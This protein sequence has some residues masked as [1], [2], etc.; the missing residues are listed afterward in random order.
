[1]CQIAL[2]VILSPPRLAQVTYAS[3]DDTIGA[4]RGSPLIHGAF[5][6][7]GDGNRRDVLSFANQVGDHP[8]RVADLEIFRLER[9]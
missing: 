4:G 3:E 2:G 7:Y 5:R 8:V 6:P 1:M 9:S